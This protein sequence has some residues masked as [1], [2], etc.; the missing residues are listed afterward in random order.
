MTVALENAV[1]SE[2]PIW[3]WAKP[4]GTSD[5]TMPVGGVASDEATAPVAWWSIPPIMAPGG[6]PRGQYRTLRLVLVLWS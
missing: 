2:P 1:G 5:Q 6:A 4:H 3:E